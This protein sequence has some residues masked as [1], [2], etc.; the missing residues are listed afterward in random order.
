MSDTGVSISTLLRTPAPATISGMWADGSYADILYH[1]RCSIAISPWSLVK[2]TTVDSARPASSTAA[3]S[4]PSI[5][6]TSAIIA[7]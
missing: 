3:S 4:R 7:K 5:A 1:C 2:M 6:S